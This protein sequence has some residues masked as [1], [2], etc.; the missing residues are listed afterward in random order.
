MHAVMATVAKQRTIESVLRRPINL[1]L[2]AIKLLRWGPVSSMVIALL[3]CNVAESYISATCQSV[4]E[5]RRVPRAVSAD[6]M[7]FV[8]LGIYMIRLELCIG[9]K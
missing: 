2:Q 9:Q 8:F 4:V 3:Y 7:V 1:L 5:W 6:H